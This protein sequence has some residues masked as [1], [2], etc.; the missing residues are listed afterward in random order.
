MLLNEEVEVEADYEF[1]VMIEL[2]DHP[3]YIAVPYMHTHIALK[4]VIDRLNLLGCT[5]QYIGMIRR[6]LDFPDS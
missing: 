6:E 3:L 5:S 2:V 1:S 4:T